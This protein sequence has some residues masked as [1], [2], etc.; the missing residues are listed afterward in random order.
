MIKL[1]VSTIKNNAVLFFLAFVL[2]TGT[3]SLFSSPPIFRDAQ[4]AYDYGMDNYKSKDSVI[5]DEIKCKNIN[6]NLNGF[7]GIDIN[8][9][10][11][12][13]RGLASEA[14]AADE[15]TA[16]ISSLGNN[17]KKYSY[18]QD[19][20]DFANICINNNNNEVIGDTGDLCS[21]GFTFVD[22]RCQKI[23]TAQATCPPD[24]R[25]ATG[26]TCITGGTTVD[27]ECP[28]GFPNGPNESG[29]CTADPPATAQAICPTSGLPAAGP[30]CPTTTPGTE[31]AECPDGFPNGPDEFGTCTADP[32]STAQAICP[33]SGL[34]AS[35]PTCPTTTSGTE[36]AVCPPGFPIGPGPTGQ[37]TGP[38]ATAQSTCPQ[39][40]YP[41]LV[42]PTRCEQNGNTPIASM[43]PP[44]TTTPP[45]SVIVNAN[46][47]K[48]STST[49]CPA[50]FPIGPAPITGTCTATQPSTAQAICP[51]SGL[52]ANGQTCPTTTPGTENAEC[53][54]GFP[55]GPD[56]TGECTADE[57]PPQQAICPTSGLPAAGP[58]CPTTT[59]GTENA[60]CPAGFP[61]GPNELGT[62]TATAPPPQQATCPGGAPATGPTCTTGGTTVPAECPAGYTGPDATGEC[63][64]VITEPP[65]E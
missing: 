14:S 49:S 32:P 10:P 52:P 13:P 4:A 11:T 2:I 35:G 25:P 42:S 45:T 64:R 60:A 55:N 38:P 34:P 62:C 3:I 31:N 50:N 46:Q 51:T 53:P 56:E 39:A 16:E 15:G 37:C 33:T 21:E 20:Q 5:V 24:D 57:L 9:L 22:G 43:C 58:T 27:A 61:N 12:A 54:D 23:E 36:N 30:T 65:N 41:N 48:C 1:S 40:N 8:A 29:T 19:E 44:S 59:P 17:E 28:D 63:Q 18:T 26:P 6:A 47:K 7:N